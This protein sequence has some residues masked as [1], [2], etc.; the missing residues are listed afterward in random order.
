MKFE[1]G[2]QV[3]LLHS[4]EEG[5]VVEVMEKGMI[6]VEVGGVDFPVF[7]DQL[8]H[9]YFKRFTE[10]RKEKKKPRSLSGEEIPKEKTKVVERKETGL[11]LALLPVYKQG[12]EGQISHFKLYYVNET[13]DKFRIHCKEFLNQEL[14]FQF[15]SEIR[16]FSR[17]YLIDF[18]FDNLNDRPRFDFEIRPVERKKNRLPVF[19]YTLKLK[20]KQVMK[21]LDAVASGEKAMFAYSLFDHYPLIEENVQEDWS[22]IQPEAKTENSYQSGYAT[23]GLPIYE[24]DLHADKLTDDLRNMNATDIL[25]LQLFTLRQ[26]LDQAIGNRQQ[27]MVIIHGIGK[28]VL[29]REVHAILKQTPEVKDFVN[30]HDFRYGFG[31]TE[32]FF[33]YK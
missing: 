33:E 19:N 21:S 22:F 29:K 12:T 8:E 16:P 3:R 6:K 10:M 18:L 23:S 27:S 26:S 4:G 7:E 2:D 13:Y 24:L 30:Q 17:L 11:Q 15:E 9:P 1:V 14:F 28:G 31:A 5:M 20:P 32:V 25:M